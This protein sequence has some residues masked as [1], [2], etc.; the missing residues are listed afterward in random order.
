MTGYKSHKTQLMEKKKK[1][2]KYGTWFTIPFFLISNSYTVKST[3]H[4][5]TVW[6]FLPVLMKQWAATWISHLGLIQVGRKDTKN[7][8]QDRLRF[9]FHIRK[10]WVLV[11]IVSCLHPLGLADHFKENIIVLWLTEHFAKTIQ[12]WLCTHSTESGD[13]VLWS[14]QFQA[15]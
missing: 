8:I 14:P 15:G 1:K 7:V 11:K 2:R 12:I 9:D 3:K 6:W 10:I 13:A 4:I 5:N